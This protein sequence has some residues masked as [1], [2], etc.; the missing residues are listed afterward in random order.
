MG[1]LLLSCSEEPTPVSLTPPSVK[2]GTICGYLRGD[3]RL[4]P[5]KS[6][7]GFEVELYQNSILLITDTT[8]ITGYFSFADLNSEA[9]ELKATTDFGFENVAYA[10][11]VFVLT[12]TLL[13]KDL[14]LD[15]LKYDFSP[16]KVGNRYTFQAARKATCWFETDSLISLIEI[17]IMDSQ[18]IGDTLF[19]YFNGIQNYTWFGSNICFITPPDSHYIIN[20]YFK[21]H[22]DQIS[23][24]VNSERGQVLSESFKGI[25]TYDGSD[26]IMRFMDMIAPLVSGRLSMGFFLRSIINNMKLFS[27][28]V[29]LMHILFGT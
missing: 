1:T 21:D 14:L 19:Y 5:N 27:L 29:S 12:D 28:N 20:G 24:V 13:E 11:D 22:N 9:Y 3:G 8:D 7:G 16:I 26:E 17:T 2:E 18:Q 10:N 4:V 15:S 25:H 23:C 6:Y